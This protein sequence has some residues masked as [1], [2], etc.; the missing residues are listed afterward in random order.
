MAGA[1]SSSVP[2]VTKADA[3]RRLARWAGAGGSGMGNGLLKDKRFRSQ[4]IKSRLDNQAAFQ[5]EG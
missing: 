3:D 1:F 5:R 2:E 4:K